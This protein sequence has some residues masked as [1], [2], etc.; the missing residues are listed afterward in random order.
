MQGRHRVIIE[1]LRPRVDGGAFPVKRVPGES[2]TALADVFTDGHDKLKAVLRYKPDDAQDWSETPMRALPN[3]L[4]Q[5]E[6]L[7][8]GMRTWRFTVLAWIDR[9]GT[10][11]DA[12]AKKV[13]AGQDV[14][15]ELRE[16]AAMVRRSADHAGPDSSRLSELAEALEGP[17]QDEAVQTALSVELLQF[18]DA[19]DPRE[20]AT[21]ADQELTVHVDPP[22]ALFSTWYEVFPRSVP[23]LKGESRHGTFADV[24]GILPEIARMG[25][26]VLYLPPI[27]PIGETKRKGR[28]NAVSAAEGDVGSPWAIGGPTPDGPG[29]HKAVHP[30]LGTLEGFRALVMAARDHN[31]EIALDIAFQCSPDHPYVID[32]PEWFKHRADGSIQ[33]AENPP[34]KY[35]DVYP[36]DFECENWRELW[37]ELKSVFTHWIEQGVR[38]FRVDNPHTKPLEFW[39]WCLGE[40]QREHP[41]TI[42]LA[43]AFT[44]PK[45]MYRLAKAGFTQSYTYFTWRNTK[46]EIEKYMTELVAHAPRDYFRP[47]FWPNTPDI[48]P[49]YLQYGGR[50]AFMIRHVLAATLSASYGIYG[51]AYELAE[52]AAV[53]GKEEY[54]DSEKYE[55]RVR[56]W[57]A[58]GNLK[59]FMTLVNTI[60]RENPALQSTW[61]L[62][63]LETDNEFVIF[64]LKDDPASGNTLLIAVNLD[65]YNSQRAWLKIP[66]KELGI[67]EGQP[68]M[69]HD[70]IGD[71]KFIWQGER[72]AIDLDPRMLPARI[73]RLRRKLKRETDFDYYL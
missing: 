65:P 5:A 29:G 48:L 31:I 47:N 28:N 6:F 39:R 13:T 15:L 66:T 60:R 49:E 37:E 73:F 14:T 21:S 63:F 58:P 45:V 22:R 71:D 57:N 23:G 12:L 62:R 17:D 9:F 33:Y 8:Q 26:D 35:E 36:F 51:P 20:F 67:P 34:K 64:Y 19:H 52:N 50:P 25:F 10:W 42:F 18:M 72:N 32:H 41:D 7:V 53:E 68:Y 55:I 3:D 46:Y 38:V 70:L 27:H 24:Q 59:E 69:V 11:R 40:I 56:N 16:G 2:V 1:N 44:R 30:D 43:E 61:N 54:L 4:F